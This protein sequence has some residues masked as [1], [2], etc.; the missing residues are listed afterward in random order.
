MSGPAQGRPPAD[1]DAETHPITGLHIFGVEP[2]RSTTGVAADV[3]ADLRFRRCV[4]RLHRLGPR[5]TAELL[6]EIGG[7]RGIQTV[8]DSKLA[9]Y[10][11]L[12]PT[13]LEA[14]GGGEFWPAPLHAPGQKVPASPIGAALDLLR[15]F[16]EN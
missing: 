4:A 1:F 12:D 8:I 6:A 14:V 9:T 11:E 16:E 15:R 7:E 2:R 3:V 5:V 13:A 10:T